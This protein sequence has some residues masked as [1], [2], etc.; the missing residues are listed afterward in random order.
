MKLA[1]RPLPPDIWA[2]TPSAAQA[3]IPTLQARVRE[4]EARPGQN[5]ANAPRPSSADPPRAPVRPKAPPSGRKR[6]GQV[7]HG[8]AFRALLAADRSRHLSAARPA[9]TGLRGGG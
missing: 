4:L 1:D 2:A 5:S 9:P 8:G 7:G 6:G 3:L